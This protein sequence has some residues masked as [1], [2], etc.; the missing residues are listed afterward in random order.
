[1]RHIIFLIVTLVTL[2]GKSQT[3]EIYKGDTINFKDKNGKKQG[4]FIVRGRHLAAQPNCFAQEKIVEQGRYHDNRKT[5]LWYEYYCNGNIKNKLI[6]VNGRPSGP[7]VMYHESG[8]KS[9]EGIWYKNRW[10]GNYTLYYNN[11]LPKQEFLFDGSGKRLGICKYYYESGKISAVAPFEDGKPT[12]YGLNL[13]KQGTIDTLMFF[14]NGVL[15]NKVIKPQGLFA[16]ELLEMYDLGYQSILKKEVQ[17]LNIESSKKDSLIVFIDQSLSKKESLLDTLEKET[18]HLKVTSSA[19]KAEN[20]VLKTK[21]KE[22]EEKA[23]RQ[24]QIIL[25]VSII[26]IIF[27]SLIVLVFLKFKQAA[28]QKLLIE[29]QKHLLEEKNQ[30]ITDSINYAQRIQKCLLASDKLLSDNLPEHFIFFQPKDI[31]SG[32]FYWANKLANGQFTLVTADSTGHGIPGALM[33]ILN[34]SCIEKAIE[35]EQLTEPADIFNHTRIKVIETLKKD[36]SNEG[37]KD[38][39]DASIICFDY[40]NSKL[41]YATA[42]NP[43]WIVRQNQ[44]IELKGDK[45][46]VGKHDKDQTPFSQYEFE[47]N[48]GD[49]IYTLTDGFPDQFGGPKGKKFMYK[50]LKETLVSISQNPMLKQKETLNS[51][52]KEWM[53]DVEQVDDITII[54]IRV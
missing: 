37:G 26:S 21:T 5:G 41:N 38:G 14:D 34:I 32:D 15:I 6:F 23:K 54:G 12:G 44:L 40:K 50:Q 2:I 13:S 36:G 53:S 4:P 8:K 31:V 27:L 33:S 49:I 42:N 19:Q 48:T 39:M 30:E 24:N 29:K 10:I 1:M 52:L 46:P 47:L 3:F 17:N 9:E 16:Q 35:S 11:G 45:M 7:A 22:Q 18:S 28:R 25:L 20:S 43:I 51:I